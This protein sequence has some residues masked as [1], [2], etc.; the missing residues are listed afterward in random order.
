MSIIENPKQSRGHYGIWIGDG[1]PPT[2]R[3]R[4]REMID[5]SLSANM[6]F[7]EFIEK[8]K[9]SGCE[10]K[11]G[12]HLA[13]KASGQQRFIRCDSLGDDYSESAIRERLNGQRIVVPAQ[14]KSSEPKIN[15]LIDIQNCI[16]AKDSP[17]YEQWC[18]V[19]NLKQAAQTLIFL[20][21]NK[22]CKYEDL[23]S[24]AQQAK[25][26]FNNISG[27]IHVID[28][29]LKEI[30]T[31]QKHIGTYQKTRDVYAEYRKSGYSKKFRESH[32]SD[33]ILNKA[34][35]NHFDELGLQKLPTIKMLQTEY[36]TLLTEKK[37]LYS[38]YYPARDFMQ[39]I[40]TAKQNTDRL[41]NYKQ[42]ELLQRNLHAER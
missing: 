2:V 18:K 13:F 16:K 33:I 40:L 34:A 10:I 42:T 7:D 30:T 31:L 4:L 19:F 9:T 6:T 26:D 35:K 3:D 8:M 39:K 37:K 20:Q 23:S 5:T 25:D 21:E 29:R 41:L 17:G 28:D 15:L 22:L 24:K 12:R 14:K 11:F 36:A 1:K 38:C 32:E 27:R